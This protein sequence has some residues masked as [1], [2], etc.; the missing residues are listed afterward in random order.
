MP[1]CNKFIQSLRSALVQLILT[2]TNGIKASPFKGNHQKNF[3]DFK[4]GPFKAESIQNPK[5][6][7]QNRN[8][9]IGV[10]VV[11]VEEQVPGLVFEGWTIQA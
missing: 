3:P 7:I 1:S 5:S 10:T 4:L 6:K 9:D 8:D 11:T 2:E